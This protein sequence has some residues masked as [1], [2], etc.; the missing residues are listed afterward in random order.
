MK[1][2]LV[3]LAL[4]FLAFTAWPLFVMWALDR[5]FPQSSGRVCDPGTPPPLHPGMNRRQAAGTAFHL[6]NP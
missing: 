6:L 2:C 4:A 3:F 1:G 5:A